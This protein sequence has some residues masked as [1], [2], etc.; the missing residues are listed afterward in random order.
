M[1]VLDRILAPQPPPFAIL[2]RPDAAGDHL[3]VLVGEVSTPDTLAGVALP[4]GGPPGHDV[5]VTSNSGC[6][7]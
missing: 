4:D 5:L 3:D 2:H 1:T 7:K 6:S